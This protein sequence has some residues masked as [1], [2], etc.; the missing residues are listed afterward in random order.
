[1]GIHLEARSENGCKTNDIFN[2]TKGQ[3]LENRAAHPPPPRIPRSTPPGVR[4]S[5]LPGLTYLL[6]QDKAVNE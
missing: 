4:Q 3:D 2:L 5:H 6:W 1:M